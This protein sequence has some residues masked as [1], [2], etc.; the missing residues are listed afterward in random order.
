[1]L[2]I[3]TTHCCRP[4]TGGLCAGV[5][6]ALATMRAGGRRIIKVGTRCACVC[7]VCVR[8]ARTTLAQWQCTH[9]NP[10]TLC[11]QAWPA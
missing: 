5:E 8:C 10:R 6:E 3:N 7:A 11:A 1:M 2:C 4:F 9:V